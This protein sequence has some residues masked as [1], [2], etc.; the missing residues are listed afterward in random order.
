MSTS[1]GRRVRCGAGWRH[2][3]QPLPWLPSR[4]WPDPSPEPAG[5]STFAGRTDDVL[6]HYAERRDTFCGRH[7]PDELASGLAP[8][9]CGLS[10]A[11][12][13]AS[14]KWLT[15]L[16]WREFY[17]AIRTT[18]R[19]AHRM[20]SGPNMTGCLGATTKTTSPSVSRRLP[21]VDAGM[22]ELNATVHAQPGRWWASFS[23]NT[24]FSIGAG[25]TVSPKNC[26][27][28]LAS[29]V[30]GWQWASGSGCDAAPYFGCSIRE[31]LQ[32]SIP[33]GPT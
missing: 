13:Q 15:E 32:N 33:Q 14:D 9:R 18:F 6:A 25:A 3:T 11:R 22:R 29:N 24:C 10:R 26:S 7:R 17:Q 1:R 23:A 31:P 30:G 20:P 19:T 5:W 8:H 4:P 27:I 2:G 16:I 21:L 28:S 12:V